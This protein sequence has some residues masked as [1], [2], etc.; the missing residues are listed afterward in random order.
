MDG[1]HISDLV[2]KFFLFY[3]TDMITEGRLYRAVPP[4]YGIK[5]KNGQMR[6]FTNRIDFSNYT[7]S[8]F[9]KTN[10]VSTMSDQRLTN[11]ELT[12]LFVTNLD[13]TYELE[14]VANTYAII[15]ELLETILFTYNTPGY[16][17]DK[18][19]KTIKSKYRFLEVKTINGIVVIEGLVDSKYHTIFLNDK[20]MKSCAHI[21]NIIKLNKYILYKLNDN[22][23]TLYQLMKIFEGTMPSN[24][25][26]YKGLG[27]QDP[28][29]LAESAL[30]PD[31]QR[32]LIKYTIADI[33]SEIESIRFYESNK[34]ELFKNLVITRQ[35]IE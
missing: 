12:S 22:A 16:T 32:T 19:K 6:Y 5:L 29:Q 30:R 8:I 7:Q 2:L 28:E 34:S 35:D 14:I 23:V 15:P 33:K 4:L 20:L 18:F 1:A 21:I 17:F 11:N 26:R 10:V 24:V 9:S 27:E 31:S 25:T 3:L 13:Y